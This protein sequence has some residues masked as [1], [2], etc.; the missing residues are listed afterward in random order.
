MFTGFSSWDTVK[1][2]DLADLSW[3]SINR[4]IANLSES[5]QIQMENNMLLVFECHI[6]FSF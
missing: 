6:H 2:K 3:Q 1:K 4:C 5:L